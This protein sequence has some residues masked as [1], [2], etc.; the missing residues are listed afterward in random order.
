MYMQQFRQCANQWV[1]WTCITSKEPTNESSALGATAPFLYYEWQL[2]RSHV[3]KE[4]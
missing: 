2:A 4:I 3:P 1:E